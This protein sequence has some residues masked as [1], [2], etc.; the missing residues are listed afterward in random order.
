MTT[1]KT[2]IDDVIRQPMSSNGSKL[3]SSFQYNVSA[4]QMKYTE[5]LCAIAACEVSG[6]ATGFVMIRSR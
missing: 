5:R 2:K 6:F 1:T 4:P 3:C